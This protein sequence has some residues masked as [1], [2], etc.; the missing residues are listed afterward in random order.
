[1]VSADNKN[2]MKRLLYPLSTLFLCFLCASALFAEDYFEQYGTS[3]PEKIL[4][5]DRGQE[6]QVFPDGRT[7]E[8][9]MTAREL[10]IWG[11]GRN[12]YLLPDCPNGDLQDHIAKVIPPEG[13]SFYLNTPGQGRVFLYLDIVSYRPLSA[14]R[15]HLDGNKCDTERNVVSFPMV[16]G[17][18]FNR[19]RWLE[20]I[21]NNRPLGMI[22]QGDNL[23]IQSPL[24]LTVDREFLMRK[25]MH[26]QLIPSP[27]DTF[28][29]IWDAYVSKE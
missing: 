20:V 22:Y 26:I 3:L 28:F 14:Y 21:V 16:K 1:M 25:S 17:S 13:I 7:S 15:P 29:A 2:T 4:F 23:Y 18:K 8:Q 12:M 19:V 9:Y 5:P 11:K 6:I 24:R 10:S 27:G